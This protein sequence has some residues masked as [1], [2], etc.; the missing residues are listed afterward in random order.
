[1]IRMKKLSKVMEIAAWALMAI[2][3]V[4]LVLLPW[5]TTWLTSQPRGE[6][7]Y[8]QYLVFLYVTGIF[9][10]LILWQCRGILH[11]V[12][13][14]EP[15]CMDT[16]KRLRRVGAI[17]LLLAVA[18]LV[19]VLFFTVFK[20]LMSFLALLFAFIG[21]TLFVFAELFAQATAYKEENDMTI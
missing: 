3:L 6:G 9:A 8:G 11:N 18:W 13:H 16:V 12:N 20:F 4:L 10:E 15:F 19:M 7:L 14:H 21:L 1:M 2:D 5:L 17:S